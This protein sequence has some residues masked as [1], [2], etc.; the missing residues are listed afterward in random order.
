MHLFYALQSGNKELI[1]LL[2]VVSGMKI[3]DIKFLC[4][5]PEGFGAYRHITFLLTVICK[6]KGF[7]RSADLCELWCECKH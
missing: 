3:F 4:L 6:M 5:K 2:V 1:K 7:S